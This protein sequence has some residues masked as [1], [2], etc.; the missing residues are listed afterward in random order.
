MQLT[1]R[2]HVAIAAQM[3]NSAGAMEKRGKGRG[4]KQKQS[5]Q[6]VKSNLRREQ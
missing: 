6:S 2:N 4:K 5:R 1:V 3:R